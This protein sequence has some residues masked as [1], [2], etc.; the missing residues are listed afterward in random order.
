MFVK[1]VQLALAHW[2]KQQT[3]LQAAVVQGVA[4]H[5]HSC[6]LRSCLF[7][8]PSLASPPVPLTPSRH[9]P[10]NLAPYPRNL[11]PYPCY[12][13]PSTVP[14]Q[15]PTCAPALAASS[16]LNLTKGMV[17]CFSCFSATE[18][19]EASLLAA[20]RAVGIASELKDC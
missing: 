8:S 5:H 15:L 3:S 17:I 9:L 14:R 7:S 16:I 20:S 10:C 11:A 12:L 19:T 1:D 13:G 2:P 6:Y 18:A 4:P